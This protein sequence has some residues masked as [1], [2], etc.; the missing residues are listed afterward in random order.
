MASA[1][2]SE[3]KLNAPE[4]SGSVEAIEEMFDKVVFGRRTKPVQTM[5]MPQVANR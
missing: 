2:T 5:K 4:D 1:K 3:V